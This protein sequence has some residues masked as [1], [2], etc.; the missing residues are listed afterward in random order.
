MSDGCFL[1]EV[2][3]RCAV[4]EVVGWVGWWGWWLRY[5]VCCDDVVRVWAQ[6]EKQTSRGEPR[7]GEQGVVVGARRAAGATRWRQRRQGAAC[8][9][10]GGGERSGEREALAA[11]RSCRRLDAGDARAAVE[12]PQ[13]HRQ[14][15]RGEPRRGEQGVVVGA[16]RRRGGGQNRGERGQAA[17]R[18]RR[19]ASRRRSACPPRR[20]RR[21]AAPETRANDGVSDS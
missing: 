6:E 13:Q 15:S 17:R 16:R 11:K 20:Q 5:L 12:R 7:R 8:A 21:A 4:R 19:G 18:G 2:G 14:T 9:A 10:S 1:S 3:C